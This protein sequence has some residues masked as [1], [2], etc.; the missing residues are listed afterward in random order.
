MYSMEVCVSTVSIIVGD[1]ALG[2]PFGGVTPWFWYLRCW[3]IRGDIVVII[4]V[5]SMG[6]EYR[7]AH[8]CETEIASLPYRCGGQV[9]RL[10][11]RV[12]IVGLFLRRANG[13]RPYSFVAVILWFCTIFIQFS[14]FKQGA[15]SAFLCDQNLSSCS[16]NSR[17]QNVSSYT[18]TLQDIRFGIIPLY[19]SRKRGALLHKKCNNCRNVAKLKNKSFVCTSLVV[20][21]CAVITQNYYRN[22]DENTRKNSVSMQLSHN[23]NI[24]QYMQ[25]W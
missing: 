11:N 22:I 13:V 24:Y 25:F 2:V 6:E 3:I 10:P 19:L 18:A 9:F 16:P 8:F 17:W 21:I 4:S 12:V 23:F 15:G 1:D 7:D 14:S 5:N 20:K